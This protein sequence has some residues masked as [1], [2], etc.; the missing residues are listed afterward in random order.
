MHKVAEPDGISI[1]EWLAQPSFSKIDLKE[2]NMRTNCWEAKKCG[3]QLGGEKCNELGVCPAS[4]EEK[5][6][7]LNGGANGGRACWAIKQTLCGDQVQG[8]FA[9]KLSG[10]LG[11]DFYLAVR[12]EEGSGF[13]TSKEI[14]ERLNG[15]AGTCA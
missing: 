13:Q 5:L 10:C 15:T 2:W 1:V 9:D 11:C 4:V 6:N 14:F 3:R 7:G 8:G 12:R